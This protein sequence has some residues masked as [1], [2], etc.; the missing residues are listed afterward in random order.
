MTYPGWLRAVPVVLQAAAVLAGVLIGN[1]AYDHWA[2]PDEP[3][4]VTTTTTVVPPTPVTEEPPL[5]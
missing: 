3:D 5:H 4:P 2:E 1:A